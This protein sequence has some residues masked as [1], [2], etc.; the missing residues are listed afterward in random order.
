MKKPSTMAESVVLLPKQKRFVDEYLVDLNGTQA[1]I[2]AGYSKRTAHV[3]ASRLLKDAKVARAVEMGRAKLSLK[4][5]VTAEEVIAELKKIGFS[6]MKSFIRI[7]KAGEPY[8][9][10]SSLTDEQAAAL[11]E[12]AVEDF[13]EGRG[14]DARE[15]RRVRIKLHDKKGALDSLC[16]HLGL[17][18]ADKHEVTGPGGQPIPHEVTV[19]FVSAKPRKD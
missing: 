2:R 15:V 17:F 7:S 5:G 14:E 16:K 10:L 4:A 8:V 18:A 13:T 11:S 9:D 6:N 12:T 3:Q 1:A 19:K